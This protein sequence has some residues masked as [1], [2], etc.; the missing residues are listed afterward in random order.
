MLF[1]NSYADDDEEALS[2]AAAARR[3]SKRKSY[4]SR[5]AADVDSDDEDYNAESD[6]SAPEAVTATPVLE[7]STPAIRKKSIWYADSNPTLQPT[8]S[9]AVKWERNKMG[10]FTK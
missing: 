2:P 6:L 8:A 7:G 1:L 5:C 9:T 3:K 10:V 4:K